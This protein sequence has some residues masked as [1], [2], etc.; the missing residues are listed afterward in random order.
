MISWRKKPRALTL[1][2]KALDSTCGRFMIIGRQTGADRFVY[3][4]FNGLS[5]VGSY[6]TAQEAK[7]S[8]NRNASNK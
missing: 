3:K 8:A 1:K 2:R 4:L 5:L 6:D 7:E